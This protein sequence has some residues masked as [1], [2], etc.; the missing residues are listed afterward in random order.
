VKNL[1]PEVHLSFASWAFFDT[2]GI[3]PTQH[4]GQWFWSE[5]W[6][7]YQVPDFSEI[8]IFAPFSMFPS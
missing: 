7:A 5:I 6:T 1:D 8:S 4:Y 2:Q 3:P